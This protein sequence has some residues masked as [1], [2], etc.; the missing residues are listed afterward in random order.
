MWLWRIWD[1]TLNRLIITQMEN[2]ILTALMEDSRMIQM[3][4]EEEG[5]SILG[6]IYVGKIK[7]IAKNINSAFVDIGNGRMAYYSLTDNW[8]H[9][10][11]A[12]GH[13]GSPKVGD[14]IIVQISKEAVKTKDP[15]ASANLSFTGRYCVLTC[16]KKQISFSSKINS[17]PWKQKIRA[18]L[19]E[20]KEED[21]GIIVR[22]NAWNVDVSVILEELEQ[23]KKKYHSL[24]DAAMYRTSGSLL[25][26]AEPSY[27][28]RLRDTYTESMEE[29]LT[30]DKEIFQ[31]VSDYLSLHQ[32][33][34]LKKLRLYSDPYVSLNKVYQLDK[35]VEETLSRHVWLRSGGYLVIEPTESMTVIDV[36]TGKY[37]GKKN[38][39]DTI[40]MINLEA[41][42]EISRQLR[43][44]NLSGIIVVDF[45]DMDEEEDQRLLLKT[46][47]A[48]CSTD[49][50]KTTVVDITKL[51]LVEVTRKKIRKPF[52]EQMGRKR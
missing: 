42:Q 50:V 25:L 3:D 12:S 46:F 43:L 4:M 10:F 20:K 30:D 21:F 23:L 35:A 6:N 9:H 16:K 2:G 49:P 39:H 28:G 13:K 22:T 31:K 41:A 26:E 14:D 51:N 44:R 40:M 1:K 52:Y 33:G 29:I 38:L 47:S 11:A 17:Q 34:D 36:N 27:I 32:P 45:I 48:Y 15:V 19:E 24:M 7:N 18:V 37:S 5:Q 8:N